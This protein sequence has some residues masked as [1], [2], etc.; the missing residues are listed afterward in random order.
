MTSEVQILSAE[1]D[2]EDGLI[3]MFSDGTIGAYVVEE[4]L[5]LRPFREQV[6]G[7]K[8]Q[9]LPQIPATHE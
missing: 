7:S 8:G 2:G 9:T 1:R 3:V 4:L 5:T 6:Q